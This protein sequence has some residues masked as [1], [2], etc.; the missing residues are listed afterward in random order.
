[1]SIDDEVKHPQLMSNPLISAE[2][3]A[4]IKIIFKKARI[5]APAGAMELT[6]ILSAQISSI[7]GIT[8]AIMFIEYI[9][10]ILYE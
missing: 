9:G 2:E 4:K 7:H 10:N 8:K 6:N 5:K 3:I 1:M